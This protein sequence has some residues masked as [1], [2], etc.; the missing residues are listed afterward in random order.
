[1]Y[2][3]RYLAQAKTD[4]LNIRDYIARES[5]S[6]AIALKYTDKL[7]HQCRKLA[8]FKAT[9]GHPRPELR[10]DIRSFPMG[11]YIIFFRY[12][13]DFLE[14]VTIIEAHRDIERLFHS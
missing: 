7:R 3:L 8:S 4:L 10:E 12:N 1:M 2:K 14:I 5:G 6:R 11:N 9:I 13:G